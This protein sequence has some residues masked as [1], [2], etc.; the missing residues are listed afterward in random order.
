MERE[1]LQK[2]VIPVASLLYICKMEEEKHSMHEGAIPQIFINA[3]SL[4]K[5]TTLAEKKLWKE[6]L[7]NKK[8]L[9]YKFRRQ[10]AFNRYIFDFY[11]H[12][13]KLSIEV[14]GEVHEDKEQKEYDT[15][16]T[17]HIEE[18]G[19]YEIRFSNKEV[20]ENIDAVNNKL[21]EI[22]KSI[23]NS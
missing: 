16:R 22:I 18:F 6:V 1:N 23:E 19:V 4:R 10:H 15:I 8:M 3:R 7:S 2:K 5:N 12:E 9:G 11:C 17:R 20:L 13:L 21:I 14:D